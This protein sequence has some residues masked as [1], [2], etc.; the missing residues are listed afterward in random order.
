M[1]TVV[2]MLP[3]FLPSLFLHNIGLSKYWNY[4]QGSTGNILSIYTQLCLI[5]YFS[6]VWVTAG[7]SRTLAI[8]RITEA[9]FCRQAA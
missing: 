8:S 1:D 5:A 9:N 2:Y 4:K 7:S 3:H 6:T